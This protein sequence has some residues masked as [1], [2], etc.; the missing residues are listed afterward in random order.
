MRDFY[1][2]GTMEEGETKTRKLLDH[3]ID[4]CPAVVAVDTETISLDDRTPV[5]VGIATSP[6]DAFYFPTYPTVSPAL[7]LYILRDP[8]VIKVHH[9]APFDVDVLDILA[10][11]IDEEFD[12]TNIR[13]TT[14]MAHL[15]MKDTYKLQ[16]LLWEVGKDYHETAEELMGRHKAKTM[17]GVPEDEI[18]KHCCLDSMATL[19]LYLKWRTEVDM[20]YLINE[21]KL[22]PILLKMSNR[23]LAIDQDKRAELDVIYTR[24]VEFLRSTAE[25]QDFNPASNQ[26][27]AY[28]LAK[29]G[30][31]LPFT[32]SRK[33]LSTDESVLEMMD[34]PIAGLVLAFRKA[35]KL[36]TTYIKPIAEDDRVY[37][38]H[39][40]TRILTWNLDW[41]PIGSLSVG[42]EIVGI[43]NFDNRTLKIVKDRVINTSSVV[44]ESYL[45]STD[46]EQMIVSNG[47][48]LWRHL[49]RSSY[50]FNSPRWS[51]TE[52]LVTGD[53]I[54]CFTTPWTYDGSREGGWMA[55]LLDGEGWVSTNEAGFSQ[56]DGPVLNR[57]I[58][59]LKSS[60]YNHFRTVSGKATGDVTA[61]RL[62][63][64][65]AMRLI[66]SVRPTRLLD[67]IDKLW[68]RNKRSIS[69]S[70]VVSITKIGKQELVDIETETHIFIAEGLIT[71][72]T[73]YHLDAVT[74]RVTSTKRNLQNWPPGES[75]S[76]IIPDSGVFKGF[77]FD[78]VE[79]RVMASVSGDLDMNRVYVE[80]GDIH[81]E[82][83]NFMNI[84]RRIAKNVNFA[85]LYGATEQCLME[86]AKIRDRRR[87]TELI[88]DWSMK[89]RGAWEWIKDTQTT[90]KR[91]GYV[92]TVF[93]RKIRLPMEERDDAIERKAV[94]YIIQ[95]S[96]AEIMKR[97]VI[98]CSH[99]P[100][101]LQIH[102]ELLWDGYQDVPEGLDNIAQFSTPVTWKELARW[103]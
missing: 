52:E 85:M 49:G 15:L 99:L 21:M 11:E 33:S 64:K 6:T 76:M 9:N 70:T 100:L 56:K 58:E 98:M 26:Q 13:D 86:T 35:N 89:F 65:E 10:K 40:T 92:E 41:T 18:A 24:E 72:N 77:D 37:C 28:I 102:D 79:L 88:H 5:G 16:W 63:V 23:G 45:I 61:I 22:V 71:H 73:H 74:G 27:V 93:G 97:A 29:R 60:G 50:Y 94:N 78:Q 68:E 43:D 4:D 2:Y 44:D 59:Y 8:S 57:G 3:L 75:R 1:Y 101:A 96:A 81:Q 84:Q 66:G 67:N 38:L 30:N 36:L 69:P 54:Q 31:F 39:P 90:G 25:S 19:A 17:L 34:D 42:D 20:P 51:R 62:S 87:C 53:F 12:S 14:V 82:T 95:G 7:P 47:K 55:G 48:H 80:G 103:E 32:K 91:Q 46:R 83:A